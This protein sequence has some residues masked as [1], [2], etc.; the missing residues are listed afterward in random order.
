MSG[1]EVALGLI[2]IVADVYAVIQIIRSDADAMRKLIWVLMVALLPAL[3]LI[4]WIFFGPRMETPQQA[5]V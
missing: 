4:A 3:G 5:G 2:V 1:L